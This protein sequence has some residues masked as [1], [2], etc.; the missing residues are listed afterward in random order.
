MPIRRHQHKEIASALKQARRKGFEVVEI[1]AGH[2]WGR[3]RAENGQELVIWSTPRSPETMA[4]RIR[5]FIRRYEE[6]GA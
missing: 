5:E 3:V 4:K 2:V 6:Q 1:N